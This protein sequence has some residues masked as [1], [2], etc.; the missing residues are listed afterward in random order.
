MASV[1]IVTLTT[2]FGLQ[3][4]FVGMLKGVILGICP[5]ARIVDISHDIPAQDIQAAGLILQRAYSYFPAGTVHLA[6]VDPGVGTARRPIAIRA[7]D[8]LF[9]GPDNGLFSIIF[10]EAEERNLPVAAFHLT[11][12]KFWLP[13]LSGIF[14]G[15]DLFSPVA[16][17][18]A[19]GVPL[20]ELGMPIDDPVRLPLPRPERTASGW[21][22]HIIAIDH[23]GNLATDLPAAWI[24]EPA[25]VVIHLAGR[26]IL[27]L[28]ATYGERLAGSLLALVDSHGRLEIA[29]S[30]GSAAGVTGLQVGGRV[31]VVES[32]H[33]ERL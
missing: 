7:G 25:K 12:K 29:V 27:G 6:I 24:K 3:D 9:V 32:T 2:D 19:S 21:H 28:S 26:E 14:H 18:L 23:F 33:V 17:Y 30:C 20:E 13:V 16:A 1:P 5:S 22:A 11:N 15:R 8:H 31:E 10:V 4:G